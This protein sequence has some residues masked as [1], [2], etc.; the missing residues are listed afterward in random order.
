MILM[1][2]ASTMAFTA[3]GQKSKVSAKVKT[4]FKEKFPNAT[5]ISWGKENA[6]EWEAEFKMNGKKYSANFDNNGN[7]KETEYRINKSDIP[8]AVKSTLDKDFIGY[9]IEVAEISETVS[10]KVYEFMIEKGNSDMEIAINSD[11]E[12]V[13]KEVKKENEENDNDEDND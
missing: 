4:A 9:K 7:W 11:G 1:V 13:K 12:L 6:K 2:L 10:G 8:S 5:K 3:C